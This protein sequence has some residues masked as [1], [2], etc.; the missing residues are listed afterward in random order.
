MKLCIDKEYQYIPEW[1][2]NK[3][4]DAPIVF[5][6]RGITDIEREKCIVKKYVDGNVEMATNESQLFRYAVKSIENLVINDKE[7]KTA[8]EFLNC[9]G[10]AGLF[11]EVV[12][13]VI[14]NTARKDLKNS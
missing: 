13:E 3:D 1:N 11:S 6:M 4:D 12:V 8:G 10:L 2:G 14:T 9:S 7:I 5:N